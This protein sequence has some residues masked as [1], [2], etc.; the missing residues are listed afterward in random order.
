[1]TVMCSVQKRFTSLL[2]TTHYSVL[3]SHSASR[4]YDLFRKGMW[5]IGP[6]M[7]GGNNKINLY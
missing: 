6:M 3:W 4:K 7:T 2:F 5:E 1:M